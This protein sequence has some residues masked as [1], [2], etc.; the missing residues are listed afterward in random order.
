MSYLESD[1]GEYDKVG[2]TAT[3]RQNETPA[4]TS[5]NKKVDEQH[6]LKPRWHFSWDIVRNLRGDRE[7]QGLEF[8]L[9]KTGTAEER[10]A[11]VRR[12]VAKIGQELRDAKSPKI[13]R[14]TWTTSTFIGR[15]A[16][17]VVS[18]IYSSRYY[19]LLG[20]ERYE[21][22]AS[23]INKLYAKY[24]GANTTLRLMENAVR[25]QAIEEERASIRL[26]IK[27]LYAQKFAI[28]D[29]IEDLNRNL[30]SV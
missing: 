20:F 30:R 11:E 15:W 1:Y 16:A 18:R 2:S 4:L 24:I 26:E 3:S 28:D 25:T 8:V 29:R 17:F 7:A 22:N 27:N 13:L 12:E 10:V 5:F 6:K 9:L 21:G 19:A 23:E 14:G